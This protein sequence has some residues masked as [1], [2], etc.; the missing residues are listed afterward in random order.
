MKAYKRIIAMMMSLSLMLGLTACG[1][2]ES[3]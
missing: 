2:T 1:Q 3:G